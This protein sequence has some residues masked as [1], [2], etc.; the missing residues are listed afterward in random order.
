MFVGFV[1]VLLLLIVLRSASGHPLLDKRGNFAVVACA[2]VVDLAP[3]IVGL[4]EKKSGHA[5]RK[6]KRKYVNDIFNELGP[7]YI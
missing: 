2:L 6:R 4:Q 5:H 7:Y 3:E 1:T